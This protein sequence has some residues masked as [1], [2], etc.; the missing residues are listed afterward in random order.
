MD[1]EKPLFHMTLDELKVEAQKRG[2]TFTDDV[3]RMD[4]LKAVT[5][6]DKAPAG[7]SG[8]GD[9][10]NNPRDIPP[11]QP[12][13]GVASG[14]KQKEVHYY[15]FTNP[16]YVDDDPRESTQLFPAGLYQFDRELPRLKG[17]K[18]ALIRHWAGKIPPHEVVEVAESVGMKPRHGEV[19]YDA[20]LQKLLSAHP[21]F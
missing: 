17:V 14:P 4:L 13:S 20:L 3:K 21:K 6:H 19:D 12:N 9:G 2:I 7:E 5:D 18:Q 16:T 10:G 15:L 1:N 11:T 8:S